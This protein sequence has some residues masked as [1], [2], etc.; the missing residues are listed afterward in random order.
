MARQ[1]QMLPTQNL[2]QEE[3]VIGSQIISAIYS[4]AETE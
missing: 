3:Y 2:C 4:L 1:Q